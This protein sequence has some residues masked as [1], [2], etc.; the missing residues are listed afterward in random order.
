TTSPTRQPAPSGRHE[1]SSK[2]T[3]STL[4]RAGNRATVPLST[5]PRCDRRADPGCRSGARDCGGGRG[6]SAGG[7]A[8]DA[9]VARRK[10]AGAGLT[11]GQAGAD[12]DARACDR[13]TRG[14]GGPERERPDRG[15][16]VGVVRGG[17]EGGRRG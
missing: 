4:R 6:T 1:A 10:G 12:E 5:S 11:L 8:P 7:E 15:A 3:P 13:G 17:G 16:G 2:W 9:V 14:G